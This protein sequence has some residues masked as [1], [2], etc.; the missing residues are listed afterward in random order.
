MRASLFRGYKDEA[1]W[2]LIYDR[3]LVAKGQSHWYSEMPRYFRP[4]TKLRQQ[5][6]FELT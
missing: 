1:F 3:R 5:F 2:F 4:G 6:S